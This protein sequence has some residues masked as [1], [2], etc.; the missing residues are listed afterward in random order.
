[1][2]LTTSRPAD[3][4][5]QGGGCAR[6]SQ[7]AVPLA[8]SDVSVIVAFPD[9]TAPDVSLTSN[10]Y[11]VTN[12]S[13]D[14]TL[15]GSPLTGSF[16]ATTSDPEGGITETEIDESWSYQCWTQVMGHW[17]IDRMHYSGSAK[18][19]SEAGATAH[20]G[21]HKGGE[22]GCEDGP[23]YSGQIR[24]AGGQNQRWWHLDNGSPGDELRPISAP[25]GPG[26]HFELRVHRLDP[27][28]QVLALSD[29]AGVHRLCLHVRLTMAHGAAH[30]RA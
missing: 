30:V 29:Q 25:G 14:V 16:D 22:F 8:A 21:F 24:V 2:T 15:P 6:G 13:A 19:A 27:P 3:W 5:W 12:H 17:E 18:R 9:D 28:V 26:G 23:V 20:W 1:M 10:G 7:C 4:S 11:T